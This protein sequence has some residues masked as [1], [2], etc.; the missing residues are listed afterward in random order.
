MGNS[1]NKSQ[2]LTKITA[3]R[4]NNIVSRQ[5]LFQRL[6]ELHEIPVVWFVGS[7][8]AGKTT[9]VS[10]YLSQHA[11]Q[12]L[13]FQVD[14]GD[15][16][17][18]TFFHYFRVAVLQ[19]APGC[20]QKLPALTP[21][22]L[23]GLTT[24]IRRY[25]EIIDTHLKKPAIIVLDN[26]DELPVD[27][28][29]HAVIVKL[30]SCLPSGVRLFILSRTEPPPA[31][32]RFLLHG[33]LT[34]LD[35]IELSLT[36]DEAQAVAAM[37]E[38]P[39]GNHFNPEQIEHAYLKTQGWIAGF[40]LLLADSRDTANGLVDQSRTQ[41]VLFDYFAE[42]VFERF[43][44]SIQHG[45]LCSV[46]L[47]VMTIANLSSLTGDSETA[48][49][50]VSLQ[51]QN[52]FVV[53]KGQA[54]P[55][56]EYHPLFRAFLLSRA[57]T[58]IPADEWRNL[59]HKAAHLLMHS[60]QIDAAANLFRIVED[61]SELAKLILREATALISAGRHQ[62]L[63]QWLGYLPSD[64]FSQYPWLSYWLGMARLP[65][66]P[67]KARNH[68]ERAYDNFRAEENAEGLYSTWAGIMDTFFYEWEDLRPADRWIAEFEMLRTNHPDFPS[69]A[70]EL[71]TYWAM[72]TLLHRQPQHSF[73]PVW[74]ERAEAI[75]NNTDAELSVLVGGYLIIFHLWQGNSLKALSLIQRLNPWT[76]APDF[77]PL[78]SIL[79]SC[80]VGFYH[81][82]RG[83]L[84]ACLRIV[85]G[86][87]AQANQTGLHCWNF[88]LSAQAARCSL[89]AGDLDGADRWI[90]NMS[91]TM[92]IHSPINGGFLEHLRTNAAAQRRDWCRAVE[93]GRKGLVMS[94]ESGIPFLEAHSHIDL[95]HALIGQGD[96]I[97]WPKHLQVAHAIGLGMN[98]NVLHYLCLE[99]EACGTFARGEEEAG[100][101]SLTQALALSREMGEPIWLMAGPQYSASIYE[102]ALTTCIE[103]E[104]VR[105]LIRK[106]RLNPSDPATAPDLWPWPVRIYTLGRFAILC[107]DEPLRSSRKTQHKPL[108]L[109]KI[110][111]AF[112]GHAIHQNRVTEA[113]WPDAEGDAADQALGTT[114]HRL[115]KLL[116]H[117]QA[118]R[119]EDRQLSLDFRYIWV[120]ALAFDS[121]AHHPGKTDQVSMQCALN[122]YHGHFLEGE[123]APWALAFRERLRSHFL[124]MSERLGSLLEDECDWL[125]AIDCY[126]RVIEIEPV[127]ESFYRRLMAC[128]AQLGQRAEALLVFQ[129][130][131]QALLSHLG[132]S[133]TRETQDLYQ[134]LM[135]S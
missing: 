102:H 104:H 107:D 91:N 88:L 98:S 47:P 103:A 56:Y 94:L 17:I 128:H 12:H 81:S 113:L 101:A 92:R 82:V 86:G 112:G 58:I 3:P 106:R 27:T 49:L 80:A 37:K 70:V 41:Q 16:N 105:Q 76:H 124:K 85:N 33:Q 66:A 65:F 79:W 1:T 89:I 11:M 21:E 69:R 75:L 8:G 55:V 121:I 28:P 5:R 122:R 114:L 63:E 40:M 117:E 84:E 23:P 129:R 7:P 59:Q 111:C 10:S 50:V 61:W 57:L 119:L 52:C 32:A 35:G 72:G 131:R 71:R 83:D 126:R 100:R 43:P 60:H 133:P 15:T 73:I 9:L 34:I 30:A 45:L 74:A 130:C 18:A 134:R 36:I 96:R 120:D 31:F 110:L 14:A 54:E 118:I 20:R 90:S 62:T 38:P 95:A 87:L 108:E 2:F 78:V 44:S 77:S 53:Q 97:E 68:F 132:V 25:A 13:W 99:T 19:A 51:R 135:E 67:S 125:A 127:T 64:L 29:L 123:S 48:A 4:A 93:H 39:G 46:L 6:D 109:I 42:E 26:Y 115:R 22:Y 116:Q 24:F